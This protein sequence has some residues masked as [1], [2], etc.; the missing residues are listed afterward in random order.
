[1]LQFDSRK[2]MQKQYRE[3]MFSH[4]LGYGKPPV[5]KLKVDRENIVNDT[6]YQLM[7]CSEEDFKK[8]LKIAF[9]GEYGVDEGGVKKEFFQLIVRKL[10]QPEF[11][12]LIIIKLL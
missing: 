3:A 8:P 6:L 11:G 5:L 2:R 9:K 1:M 10:F 12:F 7:D 4:L